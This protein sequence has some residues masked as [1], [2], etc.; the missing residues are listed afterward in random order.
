MRKAVTFLPDRLFLVSGVRKRRTKSTQ[1][2]TPLWLPQI[3]ENL[4]EDGRRVPAAFACDCIQIEEHSTTRTKI[5]AIKIIKFC[6]TYNCK[7]RIISFPS[8]KT[9]KMKMKHGCG[10]DKV[11]L[12]LYFLYMPC[13]PPKSKSVVISS[14]ICCKSDRTSLCT[15]STSSFIRA[16]SLRSEAI[17]F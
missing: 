12:Q 3:I 7:H 11:S 8:T 6:E 2:V 17:S 14:L 1:V 13:M 10:N 15:F 9:N 4:K 16:I 5:L